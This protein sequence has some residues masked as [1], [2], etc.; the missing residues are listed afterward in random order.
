MISVADD[1]SRSTRRCPG[2]GAASGLLL[3]LLFLLLSGC[4]EVQPTVSFAGDT[5]G[6]RYHITIVGSEEKFDKEMLQSL[7]EQ[8]LQELNQSLSTYIDDSELNRFNR[9]PVGTW[10]RISEDLYEVLLS[11]QQVSWLSNGA[12][13]ATI[14]PLVKLWGFGPDGPRNG[15]PSET[16]LANAQ[17]RVGYQHLELDTVEPRA[18]RN[19]DVDIDLS[20]IAKGYGVDALA[21]LLG[22]QGAEN[23]LVEIGGELV[24]AGHNAQGLP[25]RIAIERPVG[26]GN[27]GTRALQA[28][29][30]SNVALATSGDYRNYFEQ[31]GARYSHTIDPGTGKPV[32]HAL[33]SA[34][35]I[36]DS[37]MWSDALAT[38]M[39]VMGP[40]R[41]YELAEQLGVAVFLVIRANDGESFEVRANSLF[42]QYLD[43]ED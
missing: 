5:M 1:W 22:E 35:V 39:T 27:E 31:D 16:E 32:K 26:P 6:T 28:L 18:R 10:Q 42:Q 40:E 8:R 11:A 38:A 4:T 15:T 36:S 30:I 43:Q 23:Y 7:V 3:G 33:A 25:W 9:S 2:P 34:S 24:V 29:R 20:G 14:S 12:F 37:A 17:E 19:A 41:A 21:R 13:D